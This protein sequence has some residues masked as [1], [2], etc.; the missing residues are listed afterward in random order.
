M[1]ENKSKSEIYEINVG[2]T[3]DHLLEFEKHIS[4]QEISFFNP[5][6][7]ISMIC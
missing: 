5:K 3:E 4:K 1:I 7:N 2:E 6:L